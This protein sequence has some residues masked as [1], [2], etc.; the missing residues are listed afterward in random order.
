MGKGIPFRSHIV[1][2][3]GQSSEEVRIMLGVPQGSVR[4][5]LLLLRYINDVWRNLESA[6]KLFEDDFIIYIGKS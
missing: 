6:V 4:G 1:G 5:P 3:G 2:V